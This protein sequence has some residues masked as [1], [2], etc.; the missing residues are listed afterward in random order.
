MRDLAI[1]VPFLRPYRWQ[2]LLVLLSILATTSAGLL[3]PWLISSLVG[4]LNNGVTADEALRTVGG[5]AAL[6]LAAY[7]IRSIGQFFTIHL[8][9]VVAWKTCHDV[10]LALYR[11]LQRFSPAFYTQRQSGEIVSRVIKD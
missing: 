1:L 5:V 4:L 2:M 11:Q 7:G 9:H 8:A 3:A 6:L 10:R